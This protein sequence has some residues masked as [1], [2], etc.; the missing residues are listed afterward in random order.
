MAVKESLI[1]DPVCGSLDD[2]DA[3]GQQLLT[4]GS[5]HINH[6]I[7]PGVPITDA[8]AEG[9]DDVWNGKMKRL[10]YEYCSLGDLNGLITTFQRL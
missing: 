6:I 7:L 8:V 5:V 3:I 10:I 4:T 9:L 2:D 1:N